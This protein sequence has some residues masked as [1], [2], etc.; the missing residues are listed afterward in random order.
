MVILIADKA[1]FRAKTITGEGEGHCKMIKRSTHQ[2]DITIL[3]V[4]A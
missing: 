4:Y 2:D 3:N 1:G